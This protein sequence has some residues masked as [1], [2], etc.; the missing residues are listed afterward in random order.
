MGLVKLAKVLFRGVKI[1][2]A[3]EE[4]KGD[5]SNGGWEVNVNENDIKPSYSLLEQI[6]TDHEVAYRITKDDEIDNL[7][8]AIEA[9]DRQRLTIF[10]A[11]YIETPE[12]E[13][14]KPHY[15]SSG[16]MK[17]IAKSVVRN[18]AVRTLKLTGHHFNTDDRVLAFLDELQR[19]LEHPNNSSLEQL[20]LWGN[21]IEEA[22]AMKIVEIAVTIP[23]LRV[24]NLGDNRLS[25]DAKQRVEDFVAESGCSLKVRIF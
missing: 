23:S 13:Q 19:S 21:K 22:T 25:V 24:L 12:Q 11:D 14:E 3:V 17:E 5:T 15:L 4:A 6:R 8:D 10:G 16:A 2:V 18:E 20:N 7:L 9:N 1:D